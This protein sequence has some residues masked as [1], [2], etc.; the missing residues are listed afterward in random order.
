MA[1]EGEQGRNERGSVDKD[2]K[3]R[4]E[5]VTVLEACHLGRIAEPPVKPF[6]CCYLL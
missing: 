4:N 5:D 6:R 3:E 2:D 1:F